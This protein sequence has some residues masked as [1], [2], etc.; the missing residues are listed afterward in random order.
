MLAS[1]LPTPRARRFAKIMQLAHGHIEP[2]PLFPIQIVAMDE[3]LQIVIRLL[4]RLPR[5]VMEIRRLRISR[6]KR[7]RQSNRSYGQRTKM[8]HNSP[9]G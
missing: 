4:D 7:N 8:S 2:L 3:T 9:Q 5:P 1:A 6:Q